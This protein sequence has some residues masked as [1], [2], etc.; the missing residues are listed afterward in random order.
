MNI[1]RLDLTILTI[2]AKDNC[3]N[4][5]TGMTIDEINSYNEEQIACRV[6]MVRRIKHL[7]DNKYIEKGILDNK[8]FTYFITKS[9]LEVIKWEG[10]A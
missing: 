3:T 4:E 6:Q 5:L 2:L 7:C 8:A 10:R 1:N 9:G